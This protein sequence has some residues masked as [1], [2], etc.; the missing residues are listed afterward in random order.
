MRYYL[1][2]GERWLTAL[3]IAGWLVPVGYWTR[4][5]RA[6]SA[7]LAAAL[8]GVGL[9]LVAIPAGFGLRAPGA[10][11]WLAAAIGLPPKNGRGDGLEL[12]QREE[13]GHRSAVA[14][15]DPAEESR[16]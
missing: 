15:L 2:P 7:G 13:G 5:S 16:G 1:G 6:A 10:W 11:E 9:G 12:L 14:V 4:R 8:F 3:W